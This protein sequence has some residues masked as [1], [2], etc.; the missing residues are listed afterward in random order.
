MDLYDVENEFLVG[1]IRLAEDNNNQGNAERAIEEICDALRE[2]A[3]ENQKLKE[4][5]A[6]LENP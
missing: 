4:R 3:N 1:N 2:L 6:K 5:L